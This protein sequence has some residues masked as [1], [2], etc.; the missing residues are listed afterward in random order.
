MKRIEVFRFLRRLY[1]ILM[2]LVGLTFIVFPLGFHAG[3]YYMGFPQIL[4]NLSV[5]LF[6]I[7]TTLMFRLHTRQAV[8]K[9]SFLKPIL[10]VFMFIVFIALSFMEG[11][12]IRMAAT[13]EWVIPFFPLIVVT[14]LIFSTAFWGYWIFID[15]KFEN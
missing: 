3:S 8:E 13:G 10:L 5:C 9:E 15:G 7:I 4:P 2:I 1:L 14:F 6:F 11:Y 12:M